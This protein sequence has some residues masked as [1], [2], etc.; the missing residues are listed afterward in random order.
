MKRWQEYNF[1][2]SLIY[3]H[4]MFNLRVLCLRYHQS[5]RERTV[6]GNN[7][8]KHLTQY[9]PTE[10]K[11]KMLVWDK[12]KKNSRMTNSQS[13]LDYIPGLRYCKDYPPWSHSWHLQWTFYKK[14]VIV[15]VNVRSIVSNQQTLNQSWLPIQK[16][17]SPC[18]EVKLS[19]KGFLAFGLASP[20]SSPQ[21]PLFLPIHP[22]LPAVD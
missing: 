2:K 20:P 22:H 16:L 7:F 3:L 14:S 10:T 9:F 13:P 15:S 8:W 19:P 17:A 5:P 6:K 18:C 1:P 11:C 21:F 4:E 12:G